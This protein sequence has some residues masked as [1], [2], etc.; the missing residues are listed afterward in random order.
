MSDTTATATPSR[1]WSS[2]LDSVAA[3]I[4][5]Q[6]QAL[7]FGTPAP[8]DLEVDL[9]PAPL[10]DGNERLRALALLDESE[11]L[12]DCTVERLV[13]APLRRARP[14]ARRNR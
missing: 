5:L 10:A 3:Q 4:E 11:F 14:Y 6:R 7:A 1:T 2:V 9:P 13:D 8:P 12:A